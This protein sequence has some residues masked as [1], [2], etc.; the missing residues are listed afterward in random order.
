LKLLLPFSSLF[1]LAISNFDWT[2]AFGHGYSCDRAA[3]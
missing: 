3:V 2:P 1:I